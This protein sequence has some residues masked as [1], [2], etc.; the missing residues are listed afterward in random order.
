MSQNAIPDMKLEVVVIPVTDVDRAKR[1]Y[2]SL[3][4]RL[5]ADFVV[6]DSFRAVQFTPPGSAC[7]VHFGIGLT[8]ATPGSAR[9][10]FLV[11]SDIVATHAE[12]AARRVAV[13]DVFHRWVGEAPQPGPDPERRS[14]TS[15]A[16][17]SDPDGN[18]WLLQEVTARLPGRVDTGKSHSPPR[19]SSP[20]HCAAPR[21]PMA[22]TRS[23]W[24]IVMTPGR[25]GMPS[26]SC[27]SRPAGRRLRERLSWRTILRTMRSARHSARTR[28]GSRPIA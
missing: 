25:T 13:S 4:W 26:T 7:S 16:I 3:G 12:L 18:E 14:Y 17:F 5:D 9:G 27:T 22:S 8:T 1:F 15:Y 20:K 10:M 28:S 11:V 21:R 24:A 19:P 2:A 23:G 6:S